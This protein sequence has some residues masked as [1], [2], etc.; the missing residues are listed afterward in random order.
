MQLGKPVAYNSRQLKI[1]EGNYLVHDLELGAV[2]FALK[3]WR[4]YLLGERFTVYSDH[5]SLAYI[6]TQRD[7]NMRQRR[8][9][10][11]V[12]SYDFELLYHP[13]KGNVVADGLSRYPRATLSSIQI[14][15]ILADRPTLSAKVIEP[16]L[17]LRVRE[18]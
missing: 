16:G 3:T 4:H 15:H 7:L 9:L 5:K 2:V 6:F 8:W 1:H 13:G 12:A 17:L 10:E 11:Y 18:A 14:R